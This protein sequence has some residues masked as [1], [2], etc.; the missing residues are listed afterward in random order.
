MLNSYICLTLDTRAQTTQLFDA[1]SA[2]GKVE[3][4]LQDTSW[5]SYYGICADKFGIQWMFDCAEKAWFLSC[6]STQNSKILRGIS[7]AYTEV[8]VAFGLTNILFLN[9]A[10]IASLVALARNDSVVEK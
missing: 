10:V 4:A 7:L 6:N 8:K 2:G 3:M 9:N 5:D 1:L